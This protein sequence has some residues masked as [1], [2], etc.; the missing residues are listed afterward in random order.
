MLDSQESTL[1]LNRRVDI[2]V[3]VPKVNP[4][5]DPSVPEVHPVGV[6]GGD[7][8]G[9]VGGSAKPPVTYADLNPR[10]T[11]ALTNLDNAIAH[12][13][14]DVPAAA[15]IETVYTVTKDTGMRAAPDLGPMLRDV[16]KDPRSRTYTEYKV[17][18]KDGG[19]PA[20]PITDLMVSKDQRTIIN[21]VS[22]SDR[23][24]LPDAEKVRWSDQTFQ[25]WQKE[26]GT[27]ELDTV[28]QRNVQN[29]VTNDA[30]TKAHT[31][32]NI[33]AGKPGNWLPGSGPYIDFMGS[34]NG[35]P[36][37]FML[38][39]HHGDLGDLKVLSIDTYLAT[40]NRPRGLMIF[41]LGK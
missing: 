24:K 12:N 38:E 30:M 1:S 26:G 19:D 27:K 3:T 5:P 8:G 23:D 10:G 36:L 35:R 15:D 33:A 14:A 11:T 16:N 7:V 34:D 32:A 41:H 2:P 20:N 28:I 17:I 6:P 39:Q 21:E 18:N 37:A 40:S 9:S 31:D 4:H 25:A 13:V 22:Y 29:P